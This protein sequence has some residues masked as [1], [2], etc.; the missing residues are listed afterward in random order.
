MDVFRENSAG[1]GKDIIQSNLSD[2]FEFT[3]FMMLSLISKSN[4]CI[5]KDSIFAFLVDFMLDH[6]E[7]FESICCLCPF[8]FCYRR[9]M[10]L[11][12]LIRLVSFQLIIFLK[13]SVRRLA[14]QVCALK[15]LSGLLTTHANDELMFT[16]PFLEIPV[17]RYNFLLILHTF[18]MSS[19]LDLLSRAYTAEVRSLYSSDRQQYN[20]KQ[21]F[22]LLKNWLPSEL[23]HLLSSSTHCSASSSTSSISTWKNESSASSSA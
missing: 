8:G 10:V 2:I 13:Y 20:S 17:T 9:F 3:V 19:Y 5:Y 1:V 14:L 23:S 4:Q 6:H 22:S 18:N 16:I 15:D 7:T 12:A 11:F 21:H